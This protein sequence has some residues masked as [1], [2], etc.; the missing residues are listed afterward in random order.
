[1]ELPGA[2]EARGRAAA[3]AIQSLPHV[4]TCAFT[5]GALRASCETSDHNLL[6][7]LDSVKTSRLAV[8]RVYSEPPTLNDVFLEITGRELR[9]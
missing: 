9:D 7:V 5:D 8:G 2:P 3:Q 4:L 6:D 1:M